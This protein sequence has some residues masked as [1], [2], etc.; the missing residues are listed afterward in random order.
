MTILSNPAVAALSAIFVWWFSTGI[1]LYI[2]GPAAVD[3]PL[4]R[5][6]GV[7]IVCGV[8]LG[9]CRQQRG[10]VRCGCLSR[11][12][13]RRMRFGAALEIGF[14]LGLLTG[15]RSEP[16]PDGCS[17]W[18]RVAYAVQAILYH[19][20]ALVVSGA[21]VVAV[22][23]D[24]ANQIGLWTFV[25]LWAMRL[26]AKLNLFLGVPISTTQFLP[27]HLQYLTSFF[28]RG[29]STCCSRLS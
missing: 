12:H 16:C 2:V 22:T 5:A 14:L 24:G 27:S 21:A 4:V 7:H 20:L 9:A 1:I 25:V 6:C 10:P 23:W 29:R 11:L 15:P 13:V 26:S 17:G 18:R 8:A 19:E 3:V 28:T